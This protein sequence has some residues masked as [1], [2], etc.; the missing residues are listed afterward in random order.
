[1]E[2]TLYL[3][4]LNVTR[5]LTSTALNS[6]WRNSSNMKLLTNSLTDAWLQDTYLA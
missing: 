4:F 6:L 3:I 5:L 1:M 2:R